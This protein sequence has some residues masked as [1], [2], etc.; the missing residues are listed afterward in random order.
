VVAEAVG[1]FADE[2]AFRCA[3][4]F[5]VIVGRV[6]LD[7]A[8]RRSWNRALETPVLVD[9]CDW[10]T[11]RR[12]FSVLVWPPLESD[13]HTAYSDHDQR[14]EQVKQVIAKGASEMAFSTK[15][16]TDYLT[17]DHDREVWTTTDGFAIDGRRVREISRSR[18]EGVGYGA[19]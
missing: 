16:E 14:V 15:L 19:L 1:R 6:P 9:V 17:W 12:I 13:K 8:P 2:A 18:G 5:K 10:T 11:D 4:A 7:P 3:L